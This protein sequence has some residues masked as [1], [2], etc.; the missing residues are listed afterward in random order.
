MYLL[1]RYVIRLSVF[2]ACLFTASS[3]SAQGCGSPTC[4]P[5]PV[6]C[7]HCTGSWT[8]QNGGT[9]NLTS[10]GSYNVTGTVTATVAPGCPSFTYSVSGSIA[11]WP[12]QF[13]GQGYTTF[14]WNASN[15]SPLSSCAMLQRLL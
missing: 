9:W 6:P 13:G 1:V 8:D 3:L 5:N 12:G 2:A 11:R 14:T 4:E 15:P 7:A 10:D